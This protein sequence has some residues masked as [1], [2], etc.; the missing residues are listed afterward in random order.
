MN[1]IECLH[2][3][4][5]CYKAAQEAKPVGIVV[6]STGANNTSLK[7]YVQPSKSDK[8]YS[9]LIQIIGKN[10]NGNHWNRSV[11]KAVHYFIGKK[12]NGDVAV[13]HV[14]PETY[15]AWGVGKG[16]KGSYNYNPTA[17][18]QFEVCED[19]LKDKAYFEE[20]YKAAVALCADI[21]KRWGWKADVIVS[22]HEAYKKGY[23]SNHSDIDH[24][25]KKFGKTMNDFRSDV[26][27]I[28]NPPK[29]IAK[30]DIVQFTGTTHYYSANSTT[31]KKCKPGKAKVID[32]YQLGKSRHP[33]QLKAV[34]GSGSTVYG[35]VDE[36][37]IK[38]T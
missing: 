38:N 10:T 18:I 17:H 35:W 7:R 6:H 28:L 20:C 12:A 19:N 5:K 29:P 3:E 33:Y 31:A 1:I 23:G 4:S 8:K 30:G 25:L 16:K 21:C 13:A 14:H 26:D 37:D 11:D 22:H 34:S 15:C 24:W 36:K 32:I 27:K 9:S 2:T